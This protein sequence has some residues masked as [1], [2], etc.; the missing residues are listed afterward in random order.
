MLVLSYTM[1]GVMY[2]AEWSGH[3]Q[4]AHVKVAAFFWKDSEVD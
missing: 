1:H 2:Q 4:D 3:T